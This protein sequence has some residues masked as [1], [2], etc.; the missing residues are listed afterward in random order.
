MRS[1]SKVPG[2]VKPAGRLAR[3]KAMNRVLRWLPDGNS[4]AETGIAAA[5]GFL[6]GRLLQGDLSVLGQIL[7]LLGVG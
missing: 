6:A 5:V 3:I 4:A 7:V 1:P 2:T